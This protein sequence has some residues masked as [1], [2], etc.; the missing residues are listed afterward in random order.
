MGPGL[1]YLGPLKENK[2]TRRCL[3]MF[4]TRC[5]CIQYRDW[6]MNPNNPIRIIDLPMLPNISANVT[7][8]EKTLVYK[9]RHFEFD[10]RTTDGVFIYTE[11][12][13]N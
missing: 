5:M 13:D 8:F 7:Q 1:V 3:C 10:G 9:N 12:L 4:R 6:D 11:M 2:M